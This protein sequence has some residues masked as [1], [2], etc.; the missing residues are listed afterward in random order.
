MAIGADIPAA[1]PAMIRTRGMGA[2]VAAGIDLAA[3][4]SG[5]DH[6]GWRRAGYLRVRPDLLLTRLTIGLAREAGIRLRLPLASQRLQPCWSAL[7]ATP[8]PLEQ[9]NEKNEENTGERI[10]SQVESHDQSFPSGGEWADHTAFGVN[11]N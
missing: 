10:D 9:E 1:D 5:H 11:P 3:T 7:A 8:K 4:P 2:K 6:P